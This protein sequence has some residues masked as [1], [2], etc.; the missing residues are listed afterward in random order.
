MIAAFVSTTASVRRAAPHSGRDGES[1]TGAR[2]GK[3]NDGFRRRTLRNSPLP[4]PAATGF[5]QFP[6]APKC[7]ACNRERKH[8]MTDTTNLLNA[9]WTI[10]HD[11]DDY[12]CVVNASGGMISAQTGPEASDVARLIAAA[13]KLLDALANLFDQI[14]AIGI[15]DWHGAEGLSL[16]EAHTA[17]AE[18]TGDVSGRA[19]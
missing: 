9:P 11:D 12:W 7:G 17:I 10:R 18:A 1:E 16:V 3:G 8:T 4:V 13:P 6:S 2:P 15:P 14:H 19:A 5:G